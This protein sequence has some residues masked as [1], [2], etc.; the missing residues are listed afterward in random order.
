[1]KI[2]PFKRAI[3][4]LLLPLAISSMNGYAQQEEEYDDGNEI[5]FDVSRLFFELNN[6]D[7]DLGI[8]GE[9]DGNEWKYL[10]IESPTGRRLMKV[11]VNGSMRRQG[12][13][14]LFFES[15]EPKFDD[16]PPR[17]FFKR[18]PEGEYEIEAFTVNGE[19][20]EA[21]VELSH[22]MPAPVDNVKI[23]G[24][25]AAEDCDVDELP[26]ITPPIVLSWDP[27]TESHPT[28]GKEGD[29]EIE[30]Y[31]VVVEIDDTAFKSTNL[32][33]N[34]ITSYDISEDFLGLSEEFKFEIL[35]R[36][37]NGNK[38]AIESCFLIEE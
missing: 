34:T 6:T 29:V 36:H 1:M 38:T 25:P 16:L 30:Y 32:V 19:E 33:P 26:T 23:S 31:E 3:G 4:T 27:V 24:V 28:I 15:A 12:I 13:T 37:V 20:M 18:F 14:E 5:P 8:H 7:G 35:A 22:V 21:E 11:R 2:K 9:I 10:T 17:R